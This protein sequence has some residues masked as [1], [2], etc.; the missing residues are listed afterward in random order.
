MSLIATAFGSASR[1]T[2]LFGQNAY[3]LGDRCGFSQNEIDRLATA[4]VV[5]AVA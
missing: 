4:G 3:V 2:P 5:V 1:P